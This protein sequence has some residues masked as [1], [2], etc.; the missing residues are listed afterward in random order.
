[1]LVPQIFS[2]HVPGL[3]LVPSD[4]LVFREDFPLVNIPHPDAP[5]FHLSLVFNDS[6]ISL[7]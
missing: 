6:L 2:H 3:T 1:M 7:C 4:Q 5:C